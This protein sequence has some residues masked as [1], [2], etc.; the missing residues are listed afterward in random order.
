MVEWL[1]VGSFCFPWELNIHFFSSEI[2]VESSQDGLVAARHLYHFGTGT[3][4]ILSLK[5]YFQSLGK[6]Y[7]LT[8]SI[9]WLSMGFCMLL[10]LEGLSM[11]QLETDCW[12]YEAH[13]IYPKPN[14]KEQLF[15]SAPGRSGLSLSLEY[16]KHFY[17]AD[18]FGQGQ[19]ADAIEATV[20]AQSSGSGAFGS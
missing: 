10:L 4:E 16:E 17:W 20:G 2:L 3:R 13:V 11:F 8:I 9:Y 18:V 6:I 1:P 12:G 7:W 14:V 5:T 15:V 19:F